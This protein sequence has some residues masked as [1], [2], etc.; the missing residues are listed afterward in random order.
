MN[1]SSPPKRSSRPGRSSRRRK[2]KA[3]SILNAATSL[4][5]TAASP[6]P[7]AVPSDRGITLEGVKFRRIEFRRR[8]LNLPD[9]ANVNVDEYESLDPSDEQQL[10]S[11]LGFVP[12]NVVSV[13][14]RLPTEFCVSTETTPTNNR[15]SQAPSV[16][17]LYPMVIRDAFHG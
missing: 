6:F 17:K 13:A 11:Q 14:A 2:R 10:T 1:T 15:L 12:G 3:Q 4:V 7:V 9:D 16:V 8:V 5:E